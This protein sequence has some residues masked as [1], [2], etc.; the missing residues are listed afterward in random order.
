M[1]F[2]QIVPV[3]EQSTSPLTKSADRFLEDQKTLLLSEQ[4]FQIVSE[5][6]ANRHLCTDVME[7][8]EGKR[9]VQYDKYKK[10]FTVAGEKS[11][12][13]EIVAARHLGIELAL[14]AILESSGDG[15]R[16][17]KLFVERNLE[18]TLFA[19]LN[20]TLG[21]TLA[22]T[23]RREDML[24]AKAYEEIAKRSGKKSEQLGVLAEQILIGVAETIAIDR[25]DLGITV[26][27]ANAYQDVEEK[28]DFIIESKQKKRGVG[29]EA[30]ELSDEARS[31]GVQFTINTSKAV[32]KAEQIAKAKERGVHVDDIVY[33]AIEKKILQEAIEKWTKANKPIS[34][35]WAYLSVE[36]RRATLQAV[37]SGV[38]SQEQEQ[39]LLKALY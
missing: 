30:R 6:E 17:R 28:I 20:A 38:L 8:E 26:L 19:K 32:H 22:E 24:K 37:F 33:V 21:S 3:V 18:D 9:L 34:G 12:L 36:M 15:K 2:E 16:A 13:G 31:V 35:P 27:P 23:T 5:V 10:S 4:Y 7:R 25:P 11:T 39:S 1:R 14:P 29:A